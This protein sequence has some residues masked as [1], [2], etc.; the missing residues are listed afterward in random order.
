L[1]RQV[2]QPTHA[3]DRDQERLVGVQAHG[4]ELV[5]GPAQV[6]FELLG[7]G[8]AE[9]SAAQRV[10]TPLRELR[11]ELLVLRRR[12]WPPNGIA[13]SGLKSS[14]PSQI[15]LR[16]S[17]TVSHWRRCSTSSAAPVSVMW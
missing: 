4:E 12:T 3:L 8:R 16:A 5:D 14:G 9:L 17:T 11:L 1:A 13:A 10:L 15:P 7:V 2:V 6:V